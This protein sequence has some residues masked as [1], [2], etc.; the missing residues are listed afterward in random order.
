[1]YFFFDF[2]GPYGPIR[3]RMGPARTL[4]EREKIRKKRTFFLRNTS[5]KSSFLTSIIFSFD[6]F[7]VLLRFLA[8]IRLRTIL[9]SPQKA[10]SRPKTC[11]FRTTC[12]LP[13]ATVW[14]VSREV[15]LG[16]T[17]SS[18]LGLLDPGS[19]LNRHMCFLMVLMCSSDFWP[20]YTWERF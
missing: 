10:S 4:E 7:N 2:S 20:K 11:K 16:G 6:S 8:E 9:K 17:L 15:R 13:E 12:T 3:A 18:F 14:I 19:N 1:M 5:Q